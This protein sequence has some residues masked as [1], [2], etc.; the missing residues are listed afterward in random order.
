M[1]KWFFL[2]GGGVLGT[3]ARYLLTGAVAQRFGGEF[4]YGT[5]IVNMVGCFLVGLFDTLFHEKLSVSPVLRLFLMAGFCGAFTTFSTFMLETA[6]L[7]RDGET[8]RAF[9]NVMVSVALGFF[10]FRMGVLLGKI[11]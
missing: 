2:A 7:I 10:V 3:V 6:H 4:P 5:L 9:A 8:M 11:L 1:E